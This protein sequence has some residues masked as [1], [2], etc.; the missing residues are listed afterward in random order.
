MGS[1]W[2]V[3]PYGI[4]TMLLAVVAVGAAVTGTPASQFTRDPAVLLNASP[5]LGLISY[6][7]VLLWTATGAVAL[8]TAALLRRRGDE[9][10]R[11]TFLAAAG[12]LTLWLMLDD[13]FLFH[14][15]LFPEV[16]GIR[17][18]IVFAVYIILCGTF[19]V[20]FRHLILRRTNYPALVVAL[21]LLASSVAVDVLPEAWFRWDYLFLIEDGAKLLGIAGWFAYFAGASADFLLNPE[22]V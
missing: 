6:V 15:L 5:V 17:T 20:R 1:R 7:G 3:W 4:A 13:L 16:L 9:R 18:R 10:T 22:N 12:F 11:W 2:L 19:L 14:E 21:T 8:F